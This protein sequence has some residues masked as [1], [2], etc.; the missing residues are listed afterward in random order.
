MIK[1]IAERYSTNIHQPT[2]PGD[3]IFFTF[4]LP[5]FLI[6]ALESAKNHRNLIYFN[7]VTLTTPFSRGLHLKFW[8]TNKF[9]DIGKKKARE[10]SLQF[11]QPY[12]CPPK[13]YYASILSHVSISY[14]SLRKYSSFSFH[15]APSDLPL[16]PL[17]KQLALLPS[18]FSKNLYTTQGKV[19]G[20]PKLTD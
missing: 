15:T 3:V 7:L 4:P 6:Q 20:F 14:R 8:D 17:S 10:Y 12:R 2:N 9:Q 1:T 5:E 13:H 18:P 16:S 19:L 11:H